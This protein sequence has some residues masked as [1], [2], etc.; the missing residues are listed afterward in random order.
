MLSHLRKAAARLRHFAL[1]LLLF[2]L[3][4]FAFGLDGHDEAAFRSF[5]EACDR[6]Q[7]NPEFRSVAI[8]YTIRGSAA[9]RTHPFFIPTQRSILA[10]RSLPLL[11]KKFAV[12]PT[13]RLHYQNFSRGPLCAYLH[14][15]GEQGV[16]TTIG[17]VEAIGRHEAEPRRLLDSFQMDF[18]VAKDAGAIQ[19]VASL[20][21]DADASRPFTVRTNVNLLLGPEIAQIADELNF[22]QTPEEMRPDQQQAVLDRLDAHVKLHDP[23]LW[24]AK[25][26]SDFSGGV[27]TQVFGPPYKALLVP[28]VMIHDISR[29]A[30]IV[31]LAFLSLYWRRKWKRAANT[32][33]QPAPQTSTPPPRDSPAS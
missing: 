27:W 4:L 14:L 6:W 3:A 23:E 26:V 1:G 24:R 12:N 2:V 29:V 31:L 15:C 16:P 30:L 20:V 10:V 18:P 32:C 25:Q 9:M 28:I 21:H 8:D 19:S 11:P 13:S 22:P 7:S 5:S 33:H 17:V